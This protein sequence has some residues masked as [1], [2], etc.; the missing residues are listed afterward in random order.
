MTNRSKEGY[1]LLEEQWEQFVAENMREGEDENTPEE[2]THPD[3][4]LPIEEG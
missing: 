3:T 1:E 2:V 4:A